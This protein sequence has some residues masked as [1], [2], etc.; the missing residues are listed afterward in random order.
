MH[1]EYAVCIASG[2]VKSAV[3]VLHPVFSSLCAAYPCLVQYHEPCGLVSEFNPLAGRTM[4]GLAQVR[5]YRAASF[6]PGKGFVPHTQCYMIRSLSWHDQELACYSS[7][8]CAAQ[9][10][11]IHPDHGGCKLC[12]QRNHATS[13]EGTQYIGDRF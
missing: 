3:P 11:S 6:L 4:P 7:S 2:A 12:L 8:L 13:A 10:V 5:Q 9:L 1:W